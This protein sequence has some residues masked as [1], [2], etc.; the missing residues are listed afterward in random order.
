ML[1]TIKHDE[2]IPTDYITVMIY[3]EPG[4]GKSS[5]LFTANNPLV[6]DFDNGLGGIKRNRGEVVRISNWSDITALTIEDMQP[7]DTICIDTVG[8]MITKLTA[9]IIKTSPSSALGGVLNQRGWGILKARFDAWKD[10]LSS[11]KKDLVFIS[12]VTE[13][14]QGE[15]IVKRF[16]VPGGSKDILY[17][18]SDQ[19][20]Y[21]WTE[22]N[23][24]SL[25]FEPCNWKIGKNRADIPKQIIKRDDRNCLATI[26]ADIKDSMNARTEAQMQKEQTFNAVIEVIDACAQPEEFTQ[27][28]ATCKNNQTLKAYLHQAATKSGFVFNKEFMCY[29]SGEPKIQSVSSP[30]DAPGMVTDDMDDDYEGSIKAEDY[31]FKTR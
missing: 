19:I 1:K 28:I 14:K 20:G 18:G 7:F 23:N 6:L 17:Q 26:I 16:S 11:A 24:R 10:M 13:D 22:G 9:D 29:Q 5:L 2:I 8:K 3:G 31:G 30:V 12:H 4:I 21:M 27:L 15:E 25:D